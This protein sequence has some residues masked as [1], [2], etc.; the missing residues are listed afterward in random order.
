MCSVCLKALD[1][2]LRLF[3]CLIR[4][5]TKLVTC[6]PWKTEI[7][8]YIG[9]IASIGNAPD[10]RSGSLRGIGGSNPST[11]TYCRVAYVG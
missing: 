10:C 8:G 7:A 11:S 2:N 3:L 9:S 4:V 5:V 6:R 1:E